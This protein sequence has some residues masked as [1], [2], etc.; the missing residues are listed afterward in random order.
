MYLLEAKSCALHFN[1]SILT[2][3]EV[4][5]LLFTEPDSKK[6]RLILEHKFI[7]IIR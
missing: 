6:I 3:D 2:P 1:V 5:N 7:N 4:F